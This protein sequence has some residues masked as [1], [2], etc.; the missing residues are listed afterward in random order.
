[1][2]RYNQPFDKKKTPCPIKSQ[3]ITH[4]DY[5][6]LKL[7]KQYMTRY[8]KVRPRYYSGVSLRMQ[9]RLA[10]AIKRARF[11]ALIPYVR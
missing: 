3:G 2:A 4:I 8:A 6:N 5:K 11:M 9:K 10:R 1:M 7:L